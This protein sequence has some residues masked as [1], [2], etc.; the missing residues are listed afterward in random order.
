MQFR[1]SIELGLLIRKARHARGM[2][3]ADL[4]RAAGVGR[5]WIVAIEAGKPRA[6]LGKVFQV[7]AALDVSL[8]IHG[9]GILEPSSSRVRIAVPDI[10]AVVRAHEDPAP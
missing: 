8:S 6:E 3:Q 9:E 1:T 2:T 10:E 4:A 5:Q 7:L